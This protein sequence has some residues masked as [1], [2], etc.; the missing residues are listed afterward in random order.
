MD[1]QD[2]EQK[3]LDRPQS[4]LFARL[5]HTY[6]VDGKTEEAMEL[7]RSGLVSFPN[8]STAYLIYARCF[9]RRDDYISALVHLQGALNAIPDSSLLQE[10]LANWKD[11]VVR[12]NVAVTIQ[13]ED[14]SQSAAILGERAE[15]FVAP[16]NESH[17]DVSSP[18][19]P[20]EEVELL[21]AD[22]PAEPPVAA[23]LPVPLLQ[24]SNVKLQPSL[25]VVQES[26]RTV[27]TRSAAVT[28]GRIVSK[29]LAEIYATQGAYQEAILTYQLLREQRPG[30]ERE[31]EERI[32]ELESKLVAKVNP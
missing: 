26:V 20:A 19:V 25:S 2:L 1:V 3:L 14:G 9:E 5:A 32:K 28:D 13:E 4:P 15:P 22:S 31:F 21:L 18:V 30:L 17:P 27:T 10:L 29:T 16:D 11:R 12:Q 6:L 23:D 24:V 7:C 8:Y